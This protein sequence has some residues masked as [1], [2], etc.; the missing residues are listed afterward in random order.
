MT[1]VRKAPWDP[2]FPYLFLWRFEYYRLREAGQSLFYDFWALRRTRALSS[3][4]LPPVNA[5]RLL[6]FSF[7]S[8][9][10]GAFLLFASYP[11]QQGENLPR[12]DSISF[13]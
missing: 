8:S 4:S 3:F 2:H 13:P 7:F 9:D 11:V 6:T 1:R 10:F 5:S 12:L